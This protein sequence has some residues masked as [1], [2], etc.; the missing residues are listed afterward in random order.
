MKRKEKRK[1][2]LK[3][4]IYKSINIVTINDF[5]LLYIIGRGG[6]GSVWK[7]KSKAIGKYFALK[8]MSKSK[9]IDQNSERNTLQERFFL[10]KMNS[11][12][13]V[14]MLCSFQDKDNLYLVLQL[15]TG[16]DLRYHLTNYIY[17][18]TETQLK[19][20]LSNL[21]LAILYIHS[22]KII[23]RDLKPENILFDNKGYAYITD[24]GIAWSAEEDHEGDN[25]GT[26]GYM[27][28][29]TLFGLDQDYCVDYYSLGVIGYE[30]IMGK[31]PYD[32]NSRHEIKNQMNEKEAYLDI[33]ETKN[34]SD[35]CIS[36][37]NELLSRD[38][39]KRLGGKKGI[40]DI[41]GH[42]FFRGINWELIYQHKYLPP[43]YDIIKF[44]L[45]REGEVEE[46]FDN[47]YCAKKDIISETTLERYEKIK[48][49][50][51]Y[52]KCF[53]NYT[54]LC[55]DNIL[56]T[57]PKKKQIIKRIPLNLKN[58][59][60]IMNENFKRSMSINGNINYR[61]IKQ[62]KINDEMYLKQK[63]KVLARAANRSQILK[64]PY[65]KNKIKENQ[66]RENQIKGYYENKL[67]KYKE[68]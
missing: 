50:S 1:V 56:N 25:S 67:G 20:L 8:Q 28:P 49:G 15:F 58:S 41:K 63:Y 62:K 57:L 14:N 13:L 17:S 16:G 55:I 64:L 27:A 34:F 10:S 65:I 18:F 61:N 68:I 24:F 54:F 31:T 7:V 22:Q 5:E 33:K 43:I 60:E 59:G 39:K 12:F 6:F 2:N 42:Q 46:L 9:I 51:Y 47:E 32:G 19:F 30:I 3:I 11:P 29:E 52:S 21:V 36:F 35:I 40:S 23:H 66:K 45:V 44:S 48:N 4:N 53:R 26:P 38:A 37:I